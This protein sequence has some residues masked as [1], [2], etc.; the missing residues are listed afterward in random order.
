MKIQWEHS[1]TAELL[2]DLSIKGGPAGPRLRACGACRRW[3]RSAGLLD[4]MAAD[5]CKPDIVADQVIEVH[6]ED[7]PKASE[8]R[9][10]VFGRCLE[11]FR[12]PPLRHLK[13]LRSPSMG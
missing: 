8:R 6:G 3:Q 2:A 1:N 12:W 7:V 9:N 5:S 11:D 10:H 13:F 4:A